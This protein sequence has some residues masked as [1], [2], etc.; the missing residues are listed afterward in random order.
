MST[1]CE[2]SESQLSS[3]DDDLSLGGFGT[4][5]K[6]LGVYQWE[7][8][9]IAQPCL[10]ALARFGSGVYVLFAFAAILHVIVYHVVQTGKNKT[11]LL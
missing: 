2:P 1:D 5:L 9:H 4:L 10:R 8:A 7:Y 3:L 6:A 11:V